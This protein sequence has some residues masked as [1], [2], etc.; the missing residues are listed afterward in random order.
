[1]EGRRRVCNNNARHLREFSLVGS[2]FHSRSI[3]AIRVHSRFFQPRPFFGKQAAA[4]VGCA[5]VSASP[6]LSLCLRCPSCRCRNSSTL[7][8]P[9]S[10]RMGERKTRV[11][12]RPSRLRLWN[13]PITFELLTF[14][15]SSVQCPQSPSVQRHLELLLSPSLAPPSGAMAV[16][17]AP[18]AA[19][20]WSGNRLS[21]N[22]Y[23]VSIAVEEGRR[24]RGRLLIGRP[25]QS[26][27]AVP[28]LSLFGAGDDLGRS[29]VVGPKV[30]DAGRS[31]RRHC[32]AVPKQRW[33]PGKCHWAGFGGLYKE[34][35]IAYQFSKHIST[36]FKLYRSSI[37]CIL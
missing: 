18:I 25:L 34:I 15:R 13:V 8:R 3:T 7:A 11:T 28:P 17:V 21:R 27:F 20:G 12:V 35:I 4:A 14:P 26:G 31:H 37:Q 2:S 1:M 22:C 9:F 32:G 29:V 24:E 19:Y 16:V 30:A 23:V 10:D 6:S 33:L 5:A 36:S